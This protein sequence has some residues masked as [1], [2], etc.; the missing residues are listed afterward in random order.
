MKRLFVLCVV[1][2]WIVG[3]WSCSK[4]A[5]QT[6]FPP[7]APGQAVLNPAASKSDEVEKVIR[8]L[9]EDWAAAI[10]HKDL[11]TLDR[12]LADD[13]NGT[14]PTAHT[15]PKGAA[16]DD[17]KSGKYVVQAMDL[18]EISVNVYGDT[19]VSF[20]SQQEKSTYDG[21]ATSGHYHFT[22]VWIKK[23]GQWQVVASHGSRFNERL[24]GEGVRSVPKV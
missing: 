2:L 14:S 5:E 11:A 24:E 17:L 20:T 3:A 21:K 10:V 16:I 19:A 4:T 18:D 15:F 7:S 22:D 9:E 1:G 12:L 23:D 13:F 6:N 8:H